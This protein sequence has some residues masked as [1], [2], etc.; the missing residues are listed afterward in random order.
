MKTIYIIFAFLFISFA[1]F[2]QENTEKQKAEINKIKKSKN[3]IYGEATLEDEAEAMKLA[4]ELLINNINEWVASEKK[5][6][7]SEAVVIRDIVENSEGINLMRGNMYRA[8][9]YVQKKNILPVTD[10]EASVILSRSTDN[11]QEATIV[12]NDIAKVEAKTEIESDVIGL[13]GHA[14]DSA[15]DILKNILAI[16]DWNDVGPYFQELKALNRIVYGK[17]STMTSPDDCYLLIYNRDGKVVAIL[18]KGHKKNMKTLEEDS[19]NNYSGNGA[20]WFQL[21]Q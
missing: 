15:E 5:M 20:I 14:D 6:K 16:T 2:A 18:D 11:E 4:K 10:T 9:V 12:V 17:Y 21:F 19:L 3:Y 13:V 1:S 8:F 7:Q